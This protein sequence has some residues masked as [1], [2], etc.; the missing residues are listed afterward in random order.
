LIS[1]LWQIIVFQMMVT[2]DKWKGRLY[3]QSWTF[4]ILYFCM[5]Y[6]YIN[7]NTLLCYLPGWWWWVERWC[8]FWCL[9]WCRPEWQGRRWWLEW[10]CP[11]WCLPQC[12]PEWQGRRYFIAMNEYYV[13]FSFRIIVCLPWTN[14]GCR[15][16]L[17]VFLVLLGRS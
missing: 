11:F 4:C 2:S 17:C 16:R 12:R 8:P 1:T 13:C 9:P 3:C 10:W 7:F 6:L 15:R 5:H 14:T